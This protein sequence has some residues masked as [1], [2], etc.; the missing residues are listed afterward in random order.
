MLK[1]STLLIV[2]ILTL[3]IVYI[4]LSALL[5]FINNNDDTKII[6]KKM[7][8]IL[9]SV[10]SSLGI[11][12]LY[13][14]YSLNFTF[15][16]YSILMFYLIISGYIDYHSRNV[17]TFISRIFLISGVI[18]AAID[19]FYYESPIEFYIIGILGTLFLSSSL[20]FFKQL[21]WGDVE[22]YSIT[23]LYLGGFLSSMN[24]F[25]SLALAGVETVFKLIRRK[26]KLND[27]GTLCQ[28]IA[29][30]TYLIIFFVV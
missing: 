1:R 23:A 9:V 12:I 24:V 25:L 6:D 22:V 18:F 13:I 19:V 11:G 10:I 2:L 21:G 15:A 16:K 28:F 20:A 29:L 4:S 8:R 5:R 14:K 7:I 30:S 26:V 3:F 27:K 17:Y